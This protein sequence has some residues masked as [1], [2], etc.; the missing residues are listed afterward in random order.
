ML[1]LGVPTGEVAVSLGSIG[2]VATLAFSGV[3]D[4]KIAGTLL[5]AHVGYH[6]AAS[7]RR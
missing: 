3:L 4:A 7:K 5:G 1:L 2:I 6:A